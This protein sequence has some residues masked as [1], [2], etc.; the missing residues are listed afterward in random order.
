VNLRLTAVTAV[1]FAFAV[2]PA[3]AAVLNANK[4]CYREGARADP[5]KTDVVAFGGGPFT[6]GSRVSVTRDGLPLAGTLPVNAAGFISGLTTPPIIDPAPQRSFT[7][8][9]TDQANPALT[10]TLTRLVTQLAVTVRPSQGSPASR[11]RI[12]AR[13]FTGGGTLYAHIRRGRRT[14]NVRIAA[15]SGPCGTA[16]ARKRLW[17]RRTRNGV[18]RVQFDAN[19]RYSAATFPAVPFRVTIRTVLRPRSRSAATAE[20][21]ERTDGS[22]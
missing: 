5:T 18:Y 19:P 11:R 22:G 6:P 20:R 16:T 14:R 9:A 21:W 3:Q 10:G 2:A 12:A 4:L 13:G 1:A 17:P 7:L 8:V 15:I